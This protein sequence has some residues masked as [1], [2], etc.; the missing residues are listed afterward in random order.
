MFG[1]LR[2][3]RLVSEQLLQDFARHLPRLWDDPQSSP[4]H[5]KR[6]LAVTWVTIAVQLGCETRDRV[7]VEFRRL[8]NLQPPRTGVIEFCL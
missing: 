8:E 2:A 1:G 6:L 7:Q 5:K 4:E 3:D